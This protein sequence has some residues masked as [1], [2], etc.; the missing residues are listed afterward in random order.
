MIT[1]VVF[2]HIPATYDW[3][4]RYAQIIGRLGV[5]ICF[6]ISGYFLYAGMQRSG[7]FYWRKYLRNIGRILLVWLLIYAPILI[8]S[9][10]DAFHAIRE[11]ICL[12]PAYLW[13]MTALLIGCGTFVLYFFNKRIYWL[14]AIILY[15]LGC[16][17]GTYMEFLGLQD[18]WNS[19]LHVFITTRNGLFLTPIFLAMGAM[20]Y[21]LLQENPT[22][23]SAS[24]SQNMLKITAVTA[25]LYLVE[26]IFCVTTI[27]S[28]SGDRTFYMTMPLFVFMIVFVVMKSQ[29]HTILDTRICRDF[30][31]FL[32]CAQFGFIN[33][34]MFFMHYIA[35]TKP[36]GLYCFLFV[37][38]ISI[39]LF[40]ILKKRHIGRTI[41]SFLV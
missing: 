18:F 40:Y 4:A 38:C 11:L 13:F 2:L 23:L 26:V 1:S 29:L 35:N 5:P 6:T 31:T 25:C 22:P 8:H 21:Q 34:Y 9:W 28:D 36:N 15:L 19:Y 32:Y 33:I 10:P 41:L 17:G 20:I 37:I 39:L 7:L 14:L 30:S 16:S 3:M 24:L 27:A 12:T